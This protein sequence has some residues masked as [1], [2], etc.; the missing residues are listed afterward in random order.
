MIH[1]VTDESSEPPDT[2]REDEVLPALRAR[3]VPPP[4]PPLAGVRRVL[5]QAFKRGDLT[6]TQLARTLER[7][8]PPCPG[9]AQPS[10][11]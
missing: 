5:W 7:L 3:R 2:V 4:Q 9:P 6:E 8:E 1:L 11:H 10:R